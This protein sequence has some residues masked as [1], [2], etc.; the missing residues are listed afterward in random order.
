MPGATTGPYASQPVQQP[1][2]PGQEPLAVSLSGP[3]PIPIG[4]AVAER[5]QSNLQYE[6]PPAAGVPRS[7][8][9]SSNG[10]TSPPQTKPRKGTADTLSSGNTQVSSGVGSV[11]GRWDDVPHRQ[12]GRY[13]NVDGE[14]RSLMGESLTRPTQAPP[15]LHNDLGVR[16]GSARSS[17]ASSR[18]S[19]RAGGPGRVPRVGQIPE[20]DGE[21]E[22]GFRTPP[23]PNSPRTPTD[24]DRA[25]EYSDANTIDD[26]KG[27][28]Y[29]DPSRPG[30]RNGSFGRGWTRASG[31]PNF[32]PLEPGR[33]S[34]R[35]T[36]PWQQQADGGGYYPGAAVA[37]S[38]P[39]GPKGYEPVP[40]SSPTDLVAYAQFGARPEGGELL[41]S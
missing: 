22:E 28:P 9:Q 41:P 15:G 20:L 1:Y 35:G 21:G 14:G 34:S 37:T 24:S 39:G 10:N 3:V 40:S 33:G 38:S 6:R 2:S 25:S 31:R 36:G 32:Q 30:A 29:S 5:S 18:G 17:Q 13:E 23:G 19:Q 7:S 27:M 26:F 12:S 11:R 16:N 4:G 8:S